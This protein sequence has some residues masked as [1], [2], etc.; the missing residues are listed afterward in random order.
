MGVAVATI[1]TTFISIFT[2]NFSV[3]IAVLVGVIFMQVIFLNIMRTSR[4]TFAM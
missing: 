4:P 2:I 3:L 1:L